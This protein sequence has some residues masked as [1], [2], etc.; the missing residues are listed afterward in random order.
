MRYLIPLC[1]AF[2]LLCMA[3]LANAQH[4]IDV[5]RQYVQGDY[6]QAVLT[7]EK[8]PKRTRTL[9]A[10]VSAGKAAWA[11]SMPKRA[12]AVFEKALREEDIS[13][14]ERQW[15]LFSRAVI[16]Y[17]EDRFEEALAYADSALKEFPEGD[18]ITAR[19]HAL[20]GQALMRLEDYVQALEH[21]ELS[22]QSCAEE[23]Q[24]D[25]HYLIGQCQFRIGEFKQARVHLEQLSSDYEDNA[26]A[27]RMLIYISLEQELYDEAGHWLD[28]GTQLRPESFLDSWSD[29]AR[30]KIA[31]A[32]G[33]KKQVA[34]IVEHSQ[35]KYPPSDGW[36]A[37][38]EASAELYHWQ[39]A[40]EP[41]TGAAESD[42][43]DSE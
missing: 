2:V 21:L 12:L 1:Y 31:M 6:Y 24:E 34:S 43:T 5:Q 30:L 10:E 22:L 41:S 26:G 8:M 11:L 3:D 16:S 27:L 35:G 15:L 42:D 29:Y 13:E 33:D 7:Y 17:Q 25:L 32:Q 38:I 19:V 4:P 18:P 37:M 14:H 36:L 39:P 28:K 20:K 9:A 40:K 23:D